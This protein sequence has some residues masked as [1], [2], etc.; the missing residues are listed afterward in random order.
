MVGIYKITNPKGKIYIGQSI[1]IN[2]RKSAY[3]CID[4]RIMGPKIYN[5]IQKYGWENHTFEIIEEC[6]VNELFEKESYWKITTLESQGGEWNKV[7]FCNLYDI[8]SFGPLS[9]HVKNKIKGQKR[10]KETKQKMRESKLGKPSNFQN[11][12]HSVLTKQKMRESKLGK[13]SNNK[14]RKISQY[15][16]NGNFLKTWDSLK[17]IS[18]T[19]NL[20]HNS[21]HRCCQKK[22]KKAFNYIWKY[23][24][25]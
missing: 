22:Q 8:G 4:K 21:I 23:K 12:T 5:S 13:P 2:K 10:T 7:L 25:L 17:E 11:H 18:L 24:I 16:L 6:L 1:N 3:K 20:S 19:L 14:K 9:D 15:D